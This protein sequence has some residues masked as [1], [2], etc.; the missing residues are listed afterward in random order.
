M[1]YR[2]FFEENGISYAEGLSETEFDEVERIYGFSFPI[3]LRN[4][5]SQVLPTE[6]G[7]YNWRDTTDVNVMRIRQVIEEPCNGVVDGISDIEWNEEWGE[8]PDTQERKR[9]IIR[10][11]M[12]SVPQMI[13][14]YSHRYVPAIE[15]DRIPVISIRGLDMIYY[16]ITLEDYLKR[17]FQKLVAERINLESVKKIQFWSY[18][19]EEG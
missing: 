15:G 5:L 19:I 11:I 9:I 13:P 17:E 12:A 3:E 8:E 10:N 2:K 16:G 7:F 4:M 18:F 14:V 1:D 6:K